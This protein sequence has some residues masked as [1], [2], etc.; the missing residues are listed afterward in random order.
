MYSYQ[1]DAFGK[2]SRTPD[3][4]SLCLVS[5]MVWEERQDLVHYMVS[6]LLQKLTAQIY[7]CLLNVTTKLVKAWYITKHVILYQK[8]NYKVRNG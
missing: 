1:N 7:Q 3:F 5:I 4:L 2:E 6:I 8:L